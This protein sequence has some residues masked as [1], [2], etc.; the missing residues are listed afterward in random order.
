MARST[1]KITVEIDLFECDES[2]II[3]FVRK[4]YGPEDV[5]PKDELTEW[6]T[7]NGFA[8]SEN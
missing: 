2:E 4:N 3:E 8:P 7:N 1:N 6:A 5:F